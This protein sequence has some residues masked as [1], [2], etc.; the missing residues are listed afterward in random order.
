MNMV[1]LVLKRKLILGI[2]I[3]DCHLQHVNHLCHTYHNKKQICFTETNTLPF[4]LCTLSFCK[5]SVN[6]I[7]ESDEHVAGVLFEV[8]YNASRK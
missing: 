8:F 4:A 7:K 6:N 1:T 3:F 5:R 2:R